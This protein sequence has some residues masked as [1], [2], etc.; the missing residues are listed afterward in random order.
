GF[1]RCRCDI[2]TPQHRASSLGQVAHAIKRTDADGFFDLTRTRI[3][4]WV[5][6][7][8]N[9]PGQARSGER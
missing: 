3:A 6:L 9:V 7:A 4:P 2:A 1:C 8:Y 5:N